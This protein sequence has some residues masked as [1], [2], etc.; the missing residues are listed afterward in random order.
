MSMDERVAL[1]EDRVKDLTKLILYIAKETHVLPL[2]LWTGV[3]I[4]YN[5]TI[6]NARKI[7]NLPGR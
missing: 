5:D 2:G 1:L 7:D 6:I 4:V 3:L